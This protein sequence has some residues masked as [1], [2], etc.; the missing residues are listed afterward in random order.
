MPLFISVIL[1]LTFV[2][3]NYIAV[4]SITPSNALGD[5]V[6]LGVDSGPVACKICVPALSILLS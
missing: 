2:D 5:H 1:S 3:M 6:V 4:R